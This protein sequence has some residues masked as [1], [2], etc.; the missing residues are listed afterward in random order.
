MSDNVAPIATVGR[1]LPREICLM[2]IDMAVRKDPLDAWRNIRQASSWWKSM[3]EEAFAQNH[4]PQL[5]VDFYRANDRV[6]RLVFDRLSDDGTRAIFRVKDDIQEEPRNETSAP[7][8][9]HHVLVLEGVAINETPLYGFEHD[10]QAREASFFWIPTFNILLTAEARL[11]RILEGLIDDEFRRVAE[12]GLVDRGPYGE[13]NMR[14]IIFYT[15]R[16]SMQ[17]REAT[18]AERDNWFA[19]LG[20]LANPLPANN[21]P[22]TLV[23]TPTIYDNGWIH[24][25]RRHHFWH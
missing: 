3:T 25:L 18:R 7:Q 1:F 9:Y 12:T 24:M 22:H 13:T 14:K 6:G 23:W 10:E 17:Y 21:G 4:L 2:L 8:Y 19:R 5:R 16:A 15:M 20:P 11:R